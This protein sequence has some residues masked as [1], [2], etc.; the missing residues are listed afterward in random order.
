LGDVLRKH[1]PKRYK[2]SP[3]ARKE[4]S[5]WYFMQAKESPMRLV[6]ALFLLG[7]SGF[8]ISLMVNHS[9]WT[10]IAL[11]IGTLSGFAGGAGIGAFRSNKGRFPNVVIGLALLFAGSALVYWVDVSFTLLGLG[12]AG[13]NL[14]FVAFALAWLET[15][16]TN[17]QTPSEDRH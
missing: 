9:L 2:D 1:W 6:M 13:D 14:V 15:R 10:G 17:L 4:L 11:I 8:A 3:L 7:V 16:G 5:I 12:I